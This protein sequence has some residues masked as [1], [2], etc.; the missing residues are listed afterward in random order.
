MSGGWRVKGRRTSAFSE[1]QIASDGREKHRVQEMIREEGCVFTT[2]WTKKEKH[3]NEGG[4]GG[5]KLTRKRE[6]SSPRPR[7]GRR[8]ETWSTCVSLSMR[9][10]GM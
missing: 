8:L 2:E 7:H 5:Y 4:W 10:V 6:R 9:G 1:R 3:L